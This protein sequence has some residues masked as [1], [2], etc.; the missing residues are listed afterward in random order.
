MNVRTYRASRQDLNAQA[1]DG[2]GRVVSGPILDNSYSRFI[3]ITR[4]LS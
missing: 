3:S 4:D 1:S 2:T